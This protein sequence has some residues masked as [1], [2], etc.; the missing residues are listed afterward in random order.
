VSVYK[1]DKGGALGLI[2]YRCLWDQGVGGVSQCGLCSGYHH[3]FFLLHL[4]LL[5]NTFG[6]VHI[7]S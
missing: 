3:T 2:L 5:V 6:S 1:R 7:W 4:E